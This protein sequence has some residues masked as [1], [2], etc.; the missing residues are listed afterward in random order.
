MKKMP[1]SHN[2]KGNGMTPEIL[3]TE[4]IYQSG[5]FMRVRRWLKGAHPERGKLVRGWTGMETIEEVDFI[6]PVGYY[7]V[8]ENQSNSSS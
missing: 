3:N 7:T 4:I 5:S 1:K 8:M 6:K 2:G